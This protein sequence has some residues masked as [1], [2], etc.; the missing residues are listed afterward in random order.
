M[1]LSTDTTLAGRWVPPNAAQV[2]HAAS[3]T[4][5]EE[6]IL[7]HS[8]WEVQVAANTTLPGRGRDTSLLFPMLPPL[9]LRRWP[10]LASSNTSPAKGGSGTLLLPTPGQNEIQASHI[11]YTSGRQTVA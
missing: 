7:I 8:G 4:L 1:S 6:G 9:T 11:I 3:M 10:S 5:S 2:F